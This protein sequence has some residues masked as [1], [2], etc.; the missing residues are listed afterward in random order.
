MFILIPILLAGLLALVLIFLIFFEKHEND[1]KIGICKVKQ[2]GLIAYENNPLSFVANFYRNEKGDYHLVGLNSKKDRWADYTLRFANDY[3]PYLELGSAVANSLPSEQMVQVV[4]RA[5]NM[6]LIQTE[7]GRLFPLI[8]DREYKVFQ[9]NTLGLCGTNWSKE[10]RASFVNDNNLM[11]WDGAS[12]IGVY[13]MNLLTSLIPLEHPRAPETYLGIENGS[14]MSVQDCAVDYSNTSAR[15][16]VDRGYLFYNSSD[17]KQVASYRVSPTGMALSNLKLSNDSGSGFGDYKVFKEGYLAKR[18]SG[19][20]D[21]NEEWSLESLSSDSKVPIYYPLKMA[22]S[23]R[24]IGEN[25]T[26]SVWIAEQNKKFLIQKT[27]YLSLIR[28]DKPKEIFEVND[29]VAIKSLTGDGTWSSLPGN[30]HY[31]MDHSSRE[32]KYSILECQP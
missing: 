10:I 11:I 18:I 7:S 6:S 9:K 13:Q 28:P 26:E 21:K 32:L 4:A 30:L 27:Q 20:L 22:D 23:Y 24:T 12:R 29:A 14:S 5:P 1:V 25:Q 31:F 2:T 8:Q 15:I 16:S 17:S 3:S 19:F